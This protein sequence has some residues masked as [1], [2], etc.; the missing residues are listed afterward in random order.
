MDNNWLSFNA[1]EVAEAIQ[2]FNTV[3]LASM[4]RE[5]SDVIYNW[6]CNSTNNLPIPSSRLRYREEFR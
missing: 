3:R 5:A 4:A 1:F 6:L 2:N